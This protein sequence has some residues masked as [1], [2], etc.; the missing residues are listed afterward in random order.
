[1]EEPVAA[2]AS[3]RT[4]WECVQHS[5]CHLPDL[6]RSSGVRFEV[7]RLRW[8]PEHPHF[9]AGA[10]AEPVLLATASSP[11]RARTLSMAASRE[12][13]LLLCG[14]SAGGV[15]VLHLLDAVAAGM[16]SNSE[17]G[18][19]DIACSCVVHVKESHGTTATCTIS[20]RQ[21]SRPVLG[22]ELSNWLCLTACDPEAH[23]KAICHQD[24]NRHNRPSQGAAPHASPCADFAGTPHALPLVAS[25]KA[26]HAAQCVT[27]V[28]ISGHDMTS[29]GRDGSLCHY[30]CRQRGPSAEQARF[31]IHHLG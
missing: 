4:A 5:H 17:A 9:A 15:F 20:A 23:T 2:A 25:F 14:D 3:V 31:S 22:A 30:Q 11:F 29:A 21:S 10:A 19:A 26:A 28:A 8:C 18:S 1:M 6:L 16:A 27:F 7:T 24:S 13:R 12:H